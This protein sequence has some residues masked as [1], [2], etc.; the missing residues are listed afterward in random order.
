M[1]AFS[2]TL[3]VTL[4][5]VQDAAQ[6]IAGAVVH[7]PCLRSET[8]SRIAKADIWVKFENLQ[9]TASFKERGALNTLLQLTPDERKRGVIAMSAGN[10]AQ[11]VAYHAGRL[12]IPAT[13]VMPSFTP[14]TKVS[15]TRGHGA[16]VVLIGNTLAEAATEARRLAEAEKLV[17]VHPYDDPRII[18][19]QGTIALE[20]LQDA[21][22][23]DTIVV[24]VG[25]GGM[26]AGCAIAARGLKPDLKV[27]GVESSNYSAMRQLLAGEAVTAAGDTIAEGIAVRD[28]GQMPLAIA[29]ALLDRVVSVDEIAIERAIALF[30]E[31]EKT[32]TEG[33]GAT[34]LAALL[35]YPELFTGRKVG[36]VL[37]GGN[38][39]TRLL[40]SVLLRGLVRDGRIVRLRLMIGDAPGQL[41]RVATVIGKSGG[42]I[43]EVQHQRLFGVVAKAT[44]LDVTV[45]TRDRNHF[46]ELVSALNTEGFTVRVLEGADA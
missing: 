18:A 4:K 35:A 44:E 7:T 8:L 38:I 15:H 9:F 20:M 30:L 2:S 46:K 5:D 32:V 39:D 19:G 6:R 3:A 43:V 45:E 31:V 16:R 12:G 21:P 33:A 25:G 41:A 42:N 23:I 14:N 27:I 1:N 11:G 34:G 36:L 13:I 17:F 24:P 22:Q 26:I 28:I 10:H 29:R 37:S 40:A